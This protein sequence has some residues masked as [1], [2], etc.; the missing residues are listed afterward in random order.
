MRSLS[1]PEALDEALGLFERILARP[2]LEQEA[3][4]RERRQMEQGLRSQRQSAS[5]TAQRALYKA[6]YGDHPYATPPAGTEAGLAA[7]DAEQVKA[8]FERYYVAANGALAIV[9][10]LERAQAKD[11]G[12]RLLRA[13]EAGEPAAALPQPPRKPE[14]TEV[15]IELPGSQTAIMK[16]LPAVARGEEPTAYPLRVA[17]Q[18]LGGSGMVSR[19]FHA[20]REER[21]LSY[22][23]SSRLHVNAVR[24]PWIIR[25]QVQAEREGEALKVLNSAVERLAE[26]GLQEDELE[27]ATRYL[28]GSFPVALA[29]N[30]GLVRELGTMAGYDLPANHLARYIPRIEA[31]DQEAVAQALAERLVPER[32]VTVRVG[33]DMPEPHKEMAPK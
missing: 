28:T 32:M 15:R 21:G 8:F 7:L 6:M 9:G 23:T 31:V 17:N 20:M 3:V 4:A 5:E 2:S 19:L 14:R 1:R 24:G 12:E 10:D 16:G 25:S 13:I 22:S 18:A 29:S 27:Q 30:A 11:I 26:D 33:P